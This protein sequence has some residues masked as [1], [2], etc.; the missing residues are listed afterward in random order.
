MSDQ[1][2]TKIVHDKVG[3]AGVIANTC[4]N[5]RN[6]EG[7]FACREFIYFDKTCDAAIALQI[8]NGMLYENK[9]W[10]VVAARQRSSV[11]HSLSNCYQVENVLCP[12]DKV[13]NILELI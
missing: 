12:A 1:C 10:V 7:K 3:E 4:F 8:L 6:N 11:H 9:N 2:L 13:E 5:P